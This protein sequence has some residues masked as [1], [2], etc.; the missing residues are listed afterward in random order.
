METNALLLHLEKGRIL[1]LNIGKRPV[2]LIPYAALCNQA[3]QGYFP[4]CRTSRLLPQQLIS[5]YGSVH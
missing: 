2:F 3:G 5:F 4:T 1:A